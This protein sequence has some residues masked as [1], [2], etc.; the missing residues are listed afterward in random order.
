[1]IP[2]AIADIQPFFLKNLQRK[3][4]EK[5]LCMLHVIYK[6]VNGT[7]HVAP[8]ALVQRHGKNGKSDSI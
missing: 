2:K 7:F 8:I 5:I 3:G 6:N 1:M 4:E